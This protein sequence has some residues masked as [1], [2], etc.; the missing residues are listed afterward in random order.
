MTAS[1][2]LGVRCLRWLRG[3]WLHP[4]YIGTVYIRPALERAR[5]L[6]SGRM[7]D[8]GCGFRDYEPI[9]AGRV[10]Q[11]I[12]VDRPVDPNQA[13]ADVVA[14]AACLPVA[15]A[16]VDAVLATELMEHLPCPDA[17]LAEVARV[18]R[19]GGTAIVSVPFLEPLHEEPRDFF[20]FTPHSL[21]L[22]FKRHGF[23]VT[24]LWARGGWWSVVVG[25]FLNQALYDFANPRGT[26]GR[27]RRPVFG[28]LV[29]PVCAV[30]QWL[31]YHLDKLWT[32]PTYTLGYV[33]VAARTADDRPP[34]P[35]R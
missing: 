2:S 17:F 10:D 11:Y 25:S 19:S 14:D 31:G 35:G 28:A 15:S 7:L 8:I 32:S 24:H 13:R 3:S 29:L 23:E 1:T 34:S 6:V 22:L 4:R 16:S 30:L 26:D 18:L 9:F 5:P 33:V 27:R 20:R 12:G 21:R